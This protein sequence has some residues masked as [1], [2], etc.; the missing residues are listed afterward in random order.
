MK[1]LCTK[2][3]KEKGYK[4]GSLH[5]RIEKAAS[6]HLI[7]K[8]MSDR[9]HPVRLEANDQRHADMRQSYQGPQMHKRRLSLRVR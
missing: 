5:K 6:D 4:D 8:D 3:L 2:V 7:T 9:A 1:K